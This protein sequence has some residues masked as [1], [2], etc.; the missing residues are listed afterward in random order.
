MESQ[1]SSGKLF[2]DGSDDGGRSSPGSTSTNR[3]R[4]NSAQRRIS[5]ALGV[6]IAELE[7]A[8]DRADVQR[9]QAIELVRDK[10]RSLSE[11][12]TKTAQREDLH[13]N[14]ADMALLA[15]LQ[16]VCNCCC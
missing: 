9:M 6:D 13:L 16:Q 14:S 1:G 12:L 7:K 5:I 15:S 2:S 4:S 10:H 8:Q 3:T 11:R